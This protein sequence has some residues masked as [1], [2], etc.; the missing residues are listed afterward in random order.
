M[1]VIKK[2]EADDEACAELLP[3][4]HDGTV[5]L[6][7]IESSDDFEEEEIDLEI[8]DAFSWIADDLPKAS[9]Y[10]PIE[11]EPE[12]DSPPRRKSSKGKKKDV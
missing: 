2:K 8:N 3:V 11:P 10:V 1:G 4:L 5:P 6:P 9:A 12:P 7:E